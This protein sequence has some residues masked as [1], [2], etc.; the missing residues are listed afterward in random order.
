MEGRSPSHAVLQSADSWRVGY[1]VSLQKRPPYTLVS[2]LSSLETW[3]QHTYLVANSSFWD[4]VL[5]ALHIPHFVRAIEISIGHLVG[6]VPNMGQWA[7]L[8]H[9]KKDSFILC[10][11]RSYIP[12]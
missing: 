12:V 11:H 2:P 5:H 10:L 3:Q 8:S 1:T 7:T 6:D 4:T 9:T